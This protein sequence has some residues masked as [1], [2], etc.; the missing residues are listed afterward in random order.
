M[1]LVL[2]VSV[3][4]QP[5]STRILFQAMWRNAAPRRWSHRTDRAVICRTRP[6]TPHWRR[7]NREKCSTSEDGN[8]IFSASIETPSG[9]ASGW[10]S[11]VSSKTL[12]LISYDLFSLHIIGTASVGHSTRLHVESLRWCPAGISCTA[13]WVQGGEQHILLC[14]LKVQYVRS[15]Q[16]MNSYS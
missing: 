15:G 3:L 9:V 11:A 6:L 10:R 1:I 7:S 13:L 5:S 14:I 2:T 16:L 8:V 12:L 4:S